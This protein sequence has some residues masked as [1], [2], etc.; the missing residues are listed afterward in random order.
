[1]MDLDHAIDFGDEVGYMTLRQVL[2][3]M[4][5]KQA[6]SWPLFVSVDLDTYCNEI[7]A[8]ICRGPKA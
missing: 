2:L 7:V 1:M 8:V 3:G 5:T 4:K 6:S